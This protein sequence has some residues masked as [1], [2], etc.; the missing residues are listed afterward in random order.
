MQE[1]KQE[2]FEVVEENPLAVAFRWTKCP[3]KSNAK[4]AVAA[5]GRPLAVCKY[6][7]HDEAGIYCKRDEEGELETIN[8]QGE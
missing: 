3:D 1:I 2:E 5:L 8:E 6:C 4:C 7:A